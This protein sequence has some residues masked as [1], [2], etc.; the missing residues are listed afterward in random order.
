[1]IS[2]LGSHFI[3]KTEN[4][5]EELKGKG[6]NPDVIKRYILWVTISGIL[7]FLIII[8]YINFAVN[9]VNGIGSLF[10]NN[11]VFSTHLIG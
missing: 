10:G 11:T 5:R 4:K 2:H 3:V 8:K 9:T 7:L 6:K 1:M